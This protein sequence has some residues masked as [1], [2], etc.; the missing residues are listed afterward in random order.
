MFDMLYVHK[1]EIESAIDQPIMWKRKDKKRA[2][3]I[4]IVLPDAD[5]S[6]K[7]QWAKIASF[8]AKYAKML[9]DVVV[10]PRAEQIRAIVK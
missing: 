7:Q 5:Y 3:S 6:D 9:A 1:E 4:D 10:Y 8:H 2:C